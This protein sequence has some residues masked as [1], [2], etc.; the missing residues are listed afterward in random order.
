[1]E[2][3]FENRVQLACRLC[4]RALVIEGQGPEIRLFLEG[5]TSRG[6]VFVP[7]IIRG[8]LAERM[9]EEIL[10][11]QE[12]DQVFLEGELDWESRWEG[13][14]ARYLLLVNVLRIQKVE[15]F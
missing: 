15:V 12:G 14:R 11:W 7:A 13:S 10:F 5:K 8:E 2:R 3:S 1:M 9:K 6:T 4:V